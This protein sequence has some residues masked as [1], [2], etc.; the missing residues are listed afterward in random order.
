MEAKCTHCDSVAQFVITYEDAFAV[1]VQ[2]AACS[3]CADAR[4][5]RD[6]FDK[7]RLSGVEVDF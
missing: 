7:K 4:S 1:M 3:G 5:A 2:E 6:K